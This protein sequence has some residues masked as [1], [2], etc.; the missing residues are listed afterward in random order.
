MP[1]GQEVSLKCGVRQ[2]KLA[3]YYRPVWKKGFA[4]VDT[5]SPTSLYRLQRE[6]LQDFT[7]TFLNPNPTD[8]GMYS[9]DV[10]VEQENGPSFFV[11]EGSRNELLVYGK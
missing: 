2:G 3:S 9:C 8:S 7:L 11:E 1:V 4:T 6:E 10:E 5:T